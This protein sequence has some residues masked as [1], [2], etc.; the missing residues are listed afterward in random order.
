MK[1]SV[2]L[3]L[4]DANGNAGTHAPQREIYYEDCGVKGQ[5]C[6]GNGAKDD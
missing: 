4:S 1:N 6:L 2:Q 5:K 3:P